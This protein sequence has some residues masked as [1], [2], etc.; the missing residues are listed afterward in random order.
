LCSA[1]LHLAIAQESQDLP[2][3][4]GD[5]V[6]DTGTLG[7]PNSFLGFEGSR[8]INN[9]GTLAAGTDTSAPATPPFC[10][11]DWKHVQIIDLGTIEGGYESA[12]FA[13]NNRGEVVGGFVNTIQDPYS[14]F[15]LQV[16]AFLWQDGVMRDLGTLGGPDATAYFI[17]DSGQVAGNAFTDYSA[18]PVTGLPTQDPFLWENGI[19]LDLGTLGG[20]FGIANYLD[21]RG[22][23][24][25]QSNVAGDLSQHPF[26]WT[27]AHG[28]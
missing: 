19:V 18:N 6:V 24:I 7:G 9:N 10:L 17:N 27:K 11:N 13:V 20:T 28:M 2:S 26:L 23:V 12:A 15:G 5:R 21:N 25:G 16:R 1:S 22:R 4:H 8:N 14:P 3:K